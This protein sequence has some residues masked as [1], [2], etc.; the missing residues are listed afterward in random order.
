MRALTFMRVTPPPSS[1]LDA[2][3]I[4]V[5]PIMNM[6]IILVPFLMSM[7]VFTHLAIVDFGLP[8]NVGAGLDQG[9]GKPRLKLTVVVAAGY[10]ALTHGENMLDSLPAANGTYN[11]DS[12]SSRLKV[13]RAEIDIKDEAVVAVQDKIRFQDVVRVMDRCKASGFAKVGLSA[14]PEAAPTL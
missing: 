5:T 9:D 12:L 7:A 4:D 3:D 11:L 10:L 6:F 13:R 1:A 2:P 8:P 14:A